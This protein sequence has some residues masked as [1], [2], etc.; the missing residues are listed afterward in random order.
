MAGG[1]GASPDGALSRSLEENAQL[2]GS[3]RQVS[4][5]RP[6]SRVLEDRRREKMNVDPPQASAHQPLRVDPRKHLVVLDQ[7]RARQGAQEGQNL[8]PIPKVA[9][10]KLP[11]DERVAFDLAF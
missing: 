9:A 4:V 6:Q 11:D 5:R 7:Y 1:G 10:G 8:S 3:R 2:A